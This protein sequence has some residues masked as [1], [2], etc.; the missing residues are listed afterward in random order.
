M[1][2]AAAAVGAANPSNIELRKRTI[3]AAMDNASGFE[4]PAPG[5][6]LAAGQLYRVLPERETTLQPSAMV[7]ST[8]VYDVTGVTG[9]PRGEEV[10]L[11]FCCDKTFLTF[12]LVKLDDLCK[13]EVLC[14]NYFPVSSF[15]EFSAFKKSLNLVLKVII[16]WMVWAHVYL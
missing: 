9:A 1:A 3:E 11:R 6:G 15:F 4:T 16:S 13:V 14:C 8:R 2:A 12:C 7:G 5:T 10:C